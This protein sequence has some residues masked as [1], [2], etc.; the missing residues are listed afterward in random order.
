M[1]KNS[2]PSVYLDF[3]PQNSGIQLPMLLRKKNESVGQR[4]LPALACQ[5][6]TK[7]NRQIPFFRNMSLLT[8]SHPGRP[9]ASPRGSQGQPPRSPG[10]AWKVRFWPACSS[11]PPSKALGVRS[12]AAVVVYSLLELFGSSFCPVT[13]REKITPEKIV[14]KISSFPRNFR[15]SSG[16]TLRGPREEQWGCPWDRASIG[17]GRRSRASRVARL[18]AGG[19]RERERQVKGQKGERWTSRKLRFRGSSTTLPWGS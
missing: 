12:L 16:N 17:K 6:K 5:E 7:G 10:G 15:F 9:V 19:K 14:G 2:V 13:P 8:S 1:P 3:L 18:A 4:K 11:S